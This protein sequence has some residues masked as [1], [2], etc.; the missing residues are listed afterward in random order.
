M[1]VAAGLLDDGVGVGCPARNGELPGAGDTSGWT[2][3]GAA[4]GVL[5]GG[6]GA[7]AVGVGDG[8]PAEEECLGAGPA[9]CV[10]VGAGFE[11]AGLTTIVACAVTPGSVAVTG[12]VVPA[13]PAT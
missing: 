9:E 10:L 5:A 12:C 2:G 8:C 7:A 11:G 4:V 6:V 3:G 13:G 1:T